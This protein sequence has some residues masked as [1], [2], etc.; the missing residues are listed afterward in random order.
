MFALIRHA[1]YAIGSGSLTE[2]GRVDAQHLAELLAQTIPSW[3]ELHTSPAP[4]CTETAAIIGVVL[5]LPVIQDPRIA[6][7]GN[8]VDLLPPTEPHDLIFVSHLPVLTSMLRTWAKQF[9][10]AEPP[11]TQEATG[12]LIDPSHNLISTI[13][14]MKT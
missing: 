8:H 4:R 6:M 9:R 14:P 12:Y 5:Q 10:Q 11:L 7:D 2:R 13:V 1:E 3:L